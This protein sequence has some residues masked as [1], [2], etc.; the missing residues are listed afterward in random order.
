MKQPQ[1]TPEQ[2]AKLVVTAG[3]IELPTEQALKELDPLQHD[4]F[5]EALR[6][7]KDVKKPNGV[8]DPA[9]GKE[10]M[11]TVKEDVNRIAIP[12]QDLVVKRRVAFMNVGELELRSKPVTNPSSNTWTDQEK[13]FEI[14][15][16][17]RED[18]K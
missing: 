16:K 3:A 5:D 10:G 15:K 2:L 17:I 7:K 1:R 6:K 14:V 4:V 18:N 8:I 13:L 9:T 11:S 12:F